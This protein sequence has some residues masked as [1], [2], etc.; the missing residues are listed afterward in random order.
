[1]PKSLRVP[2]TAKHRHGKKR[3][4][5]L[6]TL[7]VFPDLLFQETYGDATKNGHA[8]YAGSKRKYRL[9]VSKVCGNVAEVRAQLHAEIDDIFNG[10][11]R[12]RLLPDVWKQSHPEA[13][14]EYRVEERRDKAERKQL[15][16]ARRRLA[17]RD[18]R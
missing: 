8:V 2:F 17:A 9:D 4:V 15:E 5:V 3:C 18:R 7:T 10:L 1:M 16:A 13:V 11:I 14:R 12:D 6:S